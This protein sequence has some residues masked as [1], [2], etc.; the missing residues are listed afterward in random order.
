MSST[1]RLSVPVQQDGS[2]CG[3][4][5]DAEKL[6]DELERR[7]PNATMVRGSSVPVIRAAVALQRRQPERALEQ[8]KA[9]VSYERG[10]TF[11][12]TYLR[13]QA[14]LRLRQGRDAAAEFDRILEH[15]GWDVMSPFYPLA[16]LGRARAAALDG[17][18]EG[19]RKAYEAFL[20]DWKDADTNLPVRLEAEQ[21]YERLLRTTK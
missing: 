17:N 10:W 13:G 2:L 6:V 14:Y 16:Y 1:Q 18:V 12:P 21:E 20:Q 19:A 5:S 4:A 15:R 7:F 3:N 9:S 8:L 11:L